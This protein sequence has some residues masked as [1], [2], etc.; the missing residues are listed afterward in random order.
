MKSRIIS[1]VLLVCWNM[2]EGQSLT[3]DQLLKFY[4]KGSGQRLDD[5]T[6][7]KYFDFTPNEYARKLE[8]GIIL[9]RSQNHIALTAETNCGAGGYCSSSNVSTF[10]YDGE[11]IDQAAF[12][13]GYGDCVFSK[14]RDNIYVSDSLL[15]FADLDFEIADC[16]SD[17][18]VVIKNELQIEYVFIN[19]GKFNRPIIRKID[20]RRKYYIG[21]SQFL[22]PSDLGKY[23][24]D[25]LATIR[26][27]IFASHGY[28]FDTPKWQQYF[29]QQEWYKPINKEVDKYLSM[30]ERHNIQ[31]LLKAEGK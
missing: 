26:N 2:T 24:K 29:E 21:S 13:S 9:F 3:F 30:I 27:E 8:T 23:S 20:T 10:K 6:A 31:E 18:E 15:I 28:T 17:E 22:K 14:D 4:E 5:S 7:S 16:A 1:I 12:E 19:N 25:E 11:L